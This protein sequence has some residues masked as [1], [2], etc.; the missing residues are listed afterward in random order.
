MNV[1]IVS[2]RLLQYVVTGC[3][4]KLPE[5]GYLARVKW[6]CRGAV[7]RQDIF[8]GRGVTGRLGR[9]SGMLLMLFDIRMAGSQRSGVK[10]KAALFSKHP[11]ES[12]ESQ[13][14]AQ[15]LE[16]LAG[17]K[18]KSGKCPSNWMRAWAALWKHGGGVGSWPQCRGNGKGV[19]Q[20]W[21]KPLRISC[22]CSSWVH[23]SSGDDSCF[24]ICWTICLVR[25]PFMMFGNKLEQV[26][27]VAY[28]A[29]HSAFL[30]KSV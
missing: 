5:K 14:T 22:A 30:T 21:W 6:H 10:R 28:L 24:Q 18:E 3:F 16:K 8:I 9:F 1:A 20:G 23:W 13:V 26:E 17:G 25:V 4:F 27:P 7:G 12:N 19:K 2:F 11:T 15:T 29:M